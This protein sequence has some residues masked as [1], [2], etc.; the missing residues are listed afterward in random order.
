MHI[1]VFQ[2]VSFENPAHIA[3]W[4]R[5]NKYKMTYSKLWE[6][7]VQQE[8]LDDS[9]M[10]LIMGGP[11][12]I[13]D[14]DAYKWL[15]KE[16]DAIAL[17]LQSG[18]KVMGI[19]LGAQ[20]IADIMGAMVYPG[21]APEI[22]WLPLSFNADNNLPSSQIVMHWHGDTFD[23]PFG[24]K[25][26]AS[27]EITPN[28]GFMVDN[29]VLALQFHIEMTQEALA[30]MIENCGDNLVA[31]DFVQS[32]DEILEHATKYLPACQA[33]LERWLDRFVQA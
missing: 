3:V 29:S 13:F 33:L 2:H 19:C 21:K 14:Y 12:G 30:T 1:H 23:I 24:A 10:L 18:R 8:D 26:I 15:K 22:G 31:S 25:R 17:Y 5:K 7:P 27:S 11:M 16:K 9:D 4:A 28:Q 6:Q 32:A 20:L